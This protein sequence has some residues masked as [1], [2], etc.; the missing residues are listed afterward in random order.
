MNDLKTKVEGGA[1]G[2]EQALSACFPGTRLSVTAHHSGD[3]H[4]IDIKV[5]GRYPIDHPHPYA[6]GKW[7]INITLTV[8]E[9]ICSADDIDPEHRRH[10]RFNK[11]GDSV[12]VIKWYV[13]PAD[14]DRRY[15]DHMT[16]TDAVVTACKHVCAGIVYDC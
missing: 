1:L 5:S 4:W 14:N 9:E 7:A 15:D 3:E 11:A 2:V 6:S 10:A 12:A 8:V 16:L 13:K